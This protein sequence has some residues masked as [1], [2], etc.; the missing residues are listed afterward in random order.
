IKGRVPLHL[1]SS[2][3]D[4]N[5]TYHRGEKESYVE[6]FV[7]GDFAVVVRDFYKKFHN[8]LGSVP[9]RCSVVYARLGGCYRSLVE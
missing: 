5:G 9:N 2:A 1:S 8:F 7:V 6:K 3:G 4:S